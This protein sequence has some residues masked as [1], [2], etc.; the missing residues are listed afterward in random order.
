ML[1][2]N[3]GQISTMIDVKTLET[4]LLEVLLGTAATYGINKF[5]LK[6]D[7]KPNELIQKIGVIVAADFIGDYLDDYIAGRPLSFLN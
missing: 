6:N 4:R 3:H 7:L 5:A 1:P 2:S